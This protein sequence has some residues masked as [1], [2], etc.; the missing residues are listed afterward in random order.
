[1]LDRRHSRPEG[2]AAS[3]FRSLSLSLFL[4]LFAVVIVAFTAYALLNGRAT[5]QQ[6]Q[7]TVSD[8]AL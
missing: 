6:W 4:W 1:M 2:A 3:P 7:E 5:S 8:N